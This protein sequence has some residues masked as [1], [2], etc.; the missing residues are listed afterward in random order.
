MKHLIIITVFLLGASSTWAQSGVQEPSSEVLQSCLLGT[1]RDTWASLKL[2][3]DQMERV[4]RIQ[5]ACKEECAVAATTPPTESS[6]SSADG[7]TVLA[8]LKNILTA[9]Q[10]RSWVVGCTARITSAPTPDK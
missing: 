3:T 4:R 9:E 2:T 8:E 5:E 1:V 6:I 10:Y 7:S